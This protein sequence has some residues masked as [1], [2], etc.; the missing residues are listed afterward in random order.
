M[1]RSLRHLPGAAGSGGR[2]LCAA[3]VGR[4]HPVRLPWAPAPKRLGDTQVDIP[5]SAR[6][7]AELPHPGQFCQCGGDGGP[8]NGL[9]YQ[10]KGQHLG[11]FERRC[12]RSEEHTSELQSLMRISYADICLKKTKIHNTESTRCSHKTKT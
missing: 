7:D 4:Y 3:E 8:K 11:P 10:R 1:A 2:S 5:A 6:C 12:R 9:H